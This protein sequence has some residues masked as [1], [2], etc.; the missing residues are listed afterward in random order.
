MAEAR[1]TRGQHPQKRLEASSS[2]PSHYEATGI[3]RAAA[4]CGP[5]ALPFPEARDRTFA[6]LWYLTMRRREVSSVVPYTFSFA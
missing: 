5:L 6:F 2:D 3:A 1:L 4:K